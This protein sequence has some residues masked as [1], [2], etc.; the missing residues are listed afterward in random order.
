MHRFS[1]AV[2]MAALLATSAVAS[3]ETDV[4]SVV[5]QWVDAANKGDMSKFVALC[6]K[7]STIVDDFPPF[8]WQG[9]EGCSK[10]WSANQAVAKAEGITDATVTLGKPL[11]LSIAGGHAYVITRD[12]FTFAE[13]GKRMKEA[14]ATHTLILE[15]SASGW[16]ISAETWSSASEPVPAE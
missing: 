12:D 15:K 2:A 13:K 8:V 11:R 14:S 16:R 9:A 5:H 1:V 3:E 4:M 7:Q 6:A 10:W